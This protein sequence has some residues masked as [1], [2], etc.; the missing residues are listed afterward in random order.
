MGIYSN[1]DGTHRS[2]ITLGKTTHSQLKEDAGILKYRNEGDPGWT[3]I[4][5]GTDHNDLPGLDGGDPI[6]VPK[7]FYHLTNDEY[8]FY[9]T[10][11]SPIIGVNRHIIFPAGIPVINQVLQSSDI[12]GTLQW[13]SLPAASCIELAVG[14]IKE[15]DAG[16]YSNDFVIGAKAL[17]YNAGTNPYGNRLFWDQGTS[18]FRVGFNDSTQWDNGNLG[19]YSGVIGGKNNLAFAQSSVILGGETNSILNVGSSKSSVLG[20]SSCVI[21]TAA[22]AAPTCA[23]VNGTSNLIASLATSTDCVIAGGASN[24][25]DNSLKAGILGGSSNRVGSIGFGARYGVIIGGDTNKIADTAVADNS[26]IIGG[27]DGRV[28]NASYSIVAAGSGCKIGHASYAANYGF[29]GGGLTSLIG[30]SA[31]STGSVIIGGSTNSVNATYAVNLA[32]QNNTNTGASSVA[33][34]ERCAAV[35]QGSLNIGGGYH[36]VNGTLQSIRAVV[37]KETTTGTVF[38]GLGLLNNPANYLTIAQKRSYGFEAFIAGIVKSGGTVGDSIYYKISGL[39]K[40][41]GGTTSI[42]GVPVVTLIAGD[43]SLTG[44]GDLV[45]AVADDGVDAL[46]IQVKSVDA[47]TTVMNWSATVDIIVVGHNS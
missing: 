26:A 12:N 35:H 5:G 13:G 17:T 28:D 22:I 43:V 7:E 39:I 14:V 40:N 21:G 36:T 44:A 34:G 3:P 29:I 8:D 25:I 33:M 18:A 20:G 6:T 45:T 32:G 19:S 11:T 15:T 42:V 2:T 47:A 37:G 46:I 1:F 16:T 38:T 23:I 41:V 10:L 31:I 30:Q 24:K 9:T 27:M 4:G